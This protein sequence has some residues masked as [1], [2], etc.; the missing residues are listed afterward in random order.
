MDHSY[1][2]KRET[3]QQ[4]VYISPPQFTGRWFE[5]ERF[6]D[7]LSQNTKCLSWDVQPMMRQ[8]NM[9][10]VVTSERMLTDVTSQ[11]FRLKLEGMEK[12]VTR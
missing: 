7:V 9:A 3:F 2:N 1:E 5:L 12:R 11:G 6:P 10:D 4:Y 8:D